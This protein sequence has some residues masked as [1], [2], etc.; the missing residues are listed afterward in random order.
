[1][2]LIIDHHVPLPK[3]HTSVEGRQA[4]LRAAYS[5]MV[6]GD[7]FVFQFPD[8]THAYT[9]AKSI[10]VRITTRKLEQGGFRVWRKS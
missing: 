3:G 4:E 2:T 10:G 6:P 1:M 8:I 7:S 5:Q 9:A